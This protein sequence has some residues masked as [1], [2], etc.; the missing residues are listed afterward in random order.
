[1]PGK[2]L[3]QMPASQ[4]IFAHLCVAIAHP[5]TDGEDLDDVKSV[6]NY[7]WDHYPE[8]LQA[9]VS[10]RLLDVSVYAERILLAILALFDVSAPCLPHCTDTNK[11]W[12]RR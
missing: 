4:R 11:N 10:W 8:G 3:V 2:R 12:T 6:T 1:M 5:R 7:L 9:A